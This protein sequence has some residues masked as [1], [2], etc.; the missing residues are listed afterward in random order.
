MTI[1][2]ARKIAAKKAI[3]PLRPGRGVKG[4]AGADAG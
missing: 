1:K 4:L 2:M 3:T